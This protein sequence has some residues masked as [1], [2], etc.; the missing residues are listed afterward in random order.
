[1]EIIRFSPEISRYYMLPHKEEA[2]NP[3]RFSILEAAENRIE[4]DGL[5]SLKYEVLTFNP[6]P[7]YTYIVVQL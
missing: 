4:D 7:L 1:M 6:M 3:G 5:N 2:K